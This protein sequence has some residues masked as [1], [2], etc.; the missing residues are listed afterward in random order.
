MAI[1]Q[2][3]QLSKF[4]RSAGCNTIISKAS[5]TRSSP[6]LPFHRSSPSYYFF[7]T[8]SASL[9]A[10]EPKSTPRFL[11]PNYQ[12]K[13][14]PIPKIILPPYAPL[15][16]QQ[17]DIA[18]K[19]QHQLDTANAM[20]PSYRSQTPLLLK[21]LHTNCDAMYFWKS[22]DY[23]RLAVGEDFPVE[24][25][26]GK[27]YSSGNRVTMM[28]GEYLSYL[29]LCMEQEGKEFEEYQLR[30]QH[31]HLEGKMQLSDEKEQL[32][33]AYLAQNELFQQV[34]KDIPIPHFCE[35]HGHDIG[36]GKLYHTMLWMGP[37]N[38]VSPL[39]FDP[40]DNLLMQ[41]V[42]W[43][44]VLLFPPDDQSDGTEEDDENNNGFPTRRNVSNEPSWHY[45]GIN[46][47]QYNTSAV[48]VENPDHSEYPNFKEL[49]PT[50]Y[51]CI[52]GPGDGLYIP[53]KWWHHVR[54]L[55]MSVSANVWWR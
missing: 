33:V 7:S 3:Q 15:H 13:S 43:K 17:D 30:Q 25:E 39:H 44:R 1:V 19:H 53:K 12:G 48:D 26:V 28:F 50:P 8:T 10:N 42:G 49:A 45:A 40:L 23:W 37:M 14:Q 20:R 51:E 41:V 21:N 22:L 47:N 5:I 9:A 54:S 16:K 6:K 31:P 34:I 35:N 11:I 2:L 46:G 29:T 4:A 24:V 18:T 27:S 55:E 36:E 32:D 52:L 38:T